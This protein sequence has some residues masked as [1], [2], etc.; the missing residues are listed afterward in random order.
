MLL[1]GSCTVLFAGCQTMDAG[2]KDAPRFLT[3]P[4]P[5]VTCPTSGPCAVTL[6]AA[7]GRPPE[8]IHVDQSGKSTLV[9]HLPPHS[10]LK[11]RTPGIRFAANGTNVFT[12][13]PNPTP[14]GKTVVCRNRGDVDVSGYK[15]TLFLTGPHGDFDLDPY[16]WNF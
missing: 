5:D 6:D 13:N 9:W 11:F 15:Y 4:P 8:N 3:A 10:S 7:S 2:K 12:C 1:V 16:V 14:N